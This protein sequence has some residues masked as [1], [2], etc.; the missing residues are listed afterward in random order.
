MVSQ[1]NQ[2][3]AVMSDQTNTAKALLSPEAAAAYLKDLG[4]DGAT[5]RF[6]AD[7]I[8]AGELKG[9]R[10]SRRKFVRRESLD[11]WLVRAE[12]KVRG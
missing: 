10:I 6:I 3:L 8:R 9:I 11:A 2:S 4:A 1:T 7:L 12:K 5:P